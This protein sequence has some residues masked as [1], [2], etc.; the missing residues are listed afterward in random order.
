MGYGDM[1]RMHETGS[2]TGNHFTPF[3]VVQIDESHKQNLFD[4]TT[5]R[6][7][8]SDMDSSKS[9]KQKISN[10]STFDFLL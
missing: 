1:F 7:R 9:A 2:K 4:N 5:E 3:K 6:W 10:H 8:K